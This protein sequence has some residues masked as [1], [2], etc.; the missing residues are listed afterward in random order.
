MWLLLC[1]VAC[2]EEVSWG[3]RILGIE[4]PEY[5]AKHN[6]QGE[7]NLHNLYVLSSKTGLRDFLRTGEFS[8]DQ[9][10]NAQTLFKIFIGTYFLVLPLIS[11]NAQAKGTLIS[12]GYVVP[13]KYSLTCFWLEVTLI[14]VTFLFQTQPLKLYNNTEIV[15]MLFSYVV[16]SYVL[17][18]YKS[19]LSKGIQ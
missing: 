14:H 8:Y 4:T 10:F 9:I 13:E 18:V 1:F 12:L 3:Q 19:F 2:G 5:I 6:K 11:L 16:L 15:E 17:F 7:F